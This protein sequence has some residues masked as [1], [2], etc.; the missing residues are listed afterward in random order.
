MSDKKIS[1]Q[2]VAKRLGISLAKLI[3]WQKKGALPPAP[4]RG[5][6]RFYTE[7]YV[8]EAKEFLQKHIG[9]K[10][11]KNIL[12]I[13]DSLL[14]RLVNS[15]LLNAKRIG[16]RRIFLKEEVE[17]LKKKYPT[18]KALKDIVKDQ[19]G[20]S[21]SWLAKELG[22]SR[23]TFYT[24]LRKG[25]I[26]LPKKGDKVFITSQFLREIKEKLAQRLEQAHRIKEQVL[27]SRGQ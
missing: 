7:E 24:W 4:V 12:G 2:E 10:D 15:G 26:S 13:T 6:K 16:G 18:P 3:S 5:K 11:V 27:R 20:Q 25:I 1:A 14:S 19:V 22:I 9:V 21:I 8:E 23:Q 17:E